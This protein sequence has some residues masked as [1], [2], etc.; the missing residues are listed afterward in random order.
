MGLIDGELT[1]EETHKITDLLRKDSQLREE[2]ETLTKTDDQLK[3]LTFEEPE[4]KVLKELWKSPYNH[5]AKNAA[6]WMIIG[7]YCL[8]AIYGL[9]LFFTTGSEG[10]QIKVPIAAIVIGVLILF[11]QKLRDRVH[12]HKVDRYKNIER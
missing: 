11:T 1:P 7:G 12:T 10:W 2:Y 5:A 6:L 4:D 3:G 8:L 9:F